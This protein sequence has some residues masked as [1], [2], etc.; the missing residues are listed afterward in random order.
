MSHSLRDLGDDRW[1]VVVFL[2]RDEHLRQKR[3]ARTIRAHGKREA[4]RKAVKVE[5]ELRE[6]ADRTDLTLAQ[7]S[8]DWWAAWSK[9][10]DR[11]P[12]TREDYRNILDTHI[13]P[14]RLARQPIA[15]LKTGQ[16]EA[17]YSELLEQVPGRRPVKA[18]RVKRIH[19]VMTQVFDHSI[20]NEHIVLNRTKLAD[21]PTP[22]PER[23]T[24]VAP[25]VVG[26]IVAAAY[27]AHPA[28]GRALAFA[29]RTGL[30]RGEL[31]GLRWSRILE[32]GAIL[33]DRAVVAVDPR[34]AGKVRTWPT[35]QGRVLVEK[36]TKAHNDEPIMLEDVDMLLLAQQAEWQ[37]QE[38]ELADVKLPVD[39]FL[40]ANVPPFAAPVNPNAITKWHVAA[41]KA[42]GVTGVR[43]HDLRHHHASVYLAAGATLAEAQ[44]RL[45]HKSIQT[46]MGYLEADPAR[47][48]ELLA[49]LPRLDV[50]G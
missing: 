21:K 8:E 29:G 35:G 47:Q 46:T 38:A 15:K 14:S 41:C 25:E 27:Q 11:S 12:R 9:K 23:R 30:R 19:A 43:L 3:S 50:G 24:F 4:E 10:Q 40:F 39:P 45:R 22:H 33:V 26:R 5:A 32:E 1:Q 18:S 2:G 44:Q 49:R 13:L 20:K 17:W 48:R 28:R 36:D 37:R 7:A 42:A 31:A 16:I 34:F 6:A